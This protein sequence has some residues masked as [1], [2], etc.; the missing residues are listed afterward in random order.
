MR[1][2]P[3]WFHRALVRSFTPAK[4]EQIYLCGLLHGIG[5]L[6]NALLFPQDFRYVLEEA[7]RGRA[8]L[9]DVEQHV[10]GFTHAESGRI[11]AE[12]WKLSLEIAL[13]IEYHHNPNKL[14]RRTKTL[15]LS[16]WRIRFA[17]GS[18]WATATNLPTLPPPRWNKCGARSASGFRRRRTVLWNSAWLSSSS[19]SRQPRLWWMKSFR[20][21]RSSDPA[22][23]PAFSR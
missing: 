15:F 17:R 1:W 7:S 22:G 8:A 20:Q 5:L 11:L 23:G 14:N 18:G 6:A 4:K 9:E 3:P 10:M 21:R 13:A 19:K 12:L 16:M 2:G